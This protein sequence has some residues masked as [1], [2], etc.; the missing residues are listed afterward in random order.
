MPL[1]I[2]DTIP[3]ELCPREEAAA[4]LGL[5]NPTSIDKRYVRFRNLRYAKVFYQG[6]PLLLFNRAEIESYKY[7]A[8]PPGYIRLSEAARILGFEQKYSAMVYINRHK[9]KIKKMRATRPYY[10]FKRTDIEAL[11]AHR[12]AKINRLSHETQ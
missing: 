8:P 1:T 5:K 7:T 2:I 12:Q 4:I 3:P 6:H 10:A 9:I 11:A